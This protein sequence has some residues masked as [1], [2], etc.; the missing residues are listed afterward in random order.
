MGMNIEIL[1]V[2]YRNKGALL[3][4]EAIR[5]RLS[6][7]LPEARLAVPITTPFETRS[8]YGLYAT[9]AHDAYRFDVAGIAGLL[10]AKLRAKFGL[11]APAEVDVVIDASGFGYGDYWGLRKLE[12]RLAGPVA[13]WKRPGRVAILLPQAL[14]PF[15]KPGMAAAFRRAVDA[16]D[17]VFVR[18][19]V[20]L[21]H[22]HAVVGENP[23]VRLAPDFTNLLHPT[24]PDRL[25]PLAGSAL[26]V[27]NE[28]MVAGE[29]PERREEYLR[30]LESAIAAIRRSG[31]EATIL[32]HEG[33]GDRRIAAEVNLRLDR[34]AP[35]IDEGSPLVTKAVIA[36]ADLIVSS[37]FH[38]LVSALSAGVPALACGWS[39]KYAELMGD[40][41]CAEHSF[42]LKGGG[43]AAGALDRFLADAVSAKFRA[44][45]VEA[46][47]VERNRAEAA[48]D[49]ILAM[50]KAARA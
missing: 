14:G 36:A 28:K 30:F 17:L 44:R 21:A 39:H 4:L 42:D 10:P 24:L 5:E 29:T 2:Y 31:R 33:E 13:K 45:L 8:A 22:V 25:R 27:P 16:L 41:G 11:I 47:K 15:E 3:M 6:Q 7:A 43:D 50:I 46:G 20:S 32:M 48:W 37:R 9:M 1:G 18:D 34:P 19:R 35:I 12:R 23:R 38:G 40:Y 26:V 49:E